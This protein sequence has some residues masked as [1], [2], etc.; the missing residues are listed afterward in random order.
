MGVYRLL[1]LRCEPE[2]AGDRGEP[3]ALEERS[4]GT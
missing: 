1:P 2:H 4:R 3:F